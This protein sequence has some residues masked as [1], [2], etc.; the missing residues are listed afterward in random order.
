MARW[1][2]WL[3]STSLKRGESA[4][5]VTLTFRDYTHEDRAFEMARAWVAKVRQALSSAGGDGLKIVCAKEWQ[6][7]EVVHFHLL[8]VGMG[9]SSLS[10]KRWEARWMAAGGGFAR[11]Y[12]A[13]AKAAPYLAKYSNKTR[14]GDVQVW[15]ALRGTQTPRSVQLVGCDASEDASPFRP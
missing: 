7:R 3:V 1:I 8:M 12:D 9:L 2:D 4:W 15:G 6:Q 5:F 10:R 11:V 13:Q 14:G